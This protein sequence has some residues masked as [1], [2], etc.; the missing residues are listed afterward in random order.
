MSVQPTERS[1]LA[2]PG[3]LIRQ[4]R[5]APGNH[6]QLGG[7]S[8]RSNTFGHVM[9]C[10][11][12]ARMCRHSGCT[13]LHAQV[14]RPGPELARAS[15]ELDEGDQQ[16]A[17]RWHRADAG[18]QCRNLDIIIN[19]L[20]SSLLGGNEKHLFHICLISVI[21]S[22]PNSILDIIVKSMIWFSNNSISCVFA[23]S[24]FIDISVFFIFSFF[25]FYCTC[26]A[27]K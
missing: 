6:T 10:T 20:I 11:S 27:N 17:P 24:L 22:S 12:R 3:S 2:E 25:I 26:R 19:L 1:L 13:P 4:Y 5:C 9:L 14:H 8:P 21:T 23:C 7:I 16:R 15:P 18:P